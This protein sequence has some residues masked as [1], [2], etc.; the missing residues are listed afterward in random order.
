M[1]DYVVTLQMTVEADCEAD[2]LQDVL[3]QIRAK[4]HDRD[5]IACDVELIE[6]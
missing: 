1:N 5:A 6:E 3:E 4:S 2:A